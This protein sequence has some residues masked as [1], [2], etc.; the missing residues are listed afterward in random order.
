MVNYKI[1]FSDVDG[2]L[3]NTRHQVLP[4]TLLAIKSLQKQ[5][6]PFVI[7]SARSPSGIYPIQEKYGFNCPVISYSGALIMDE[8]K[9]VLYSKGFSRDLAG[10]VIEFIE[11]SRFDCSWNIYSKDT[12]V[13]KDRK[14]PRVAREENIVQAKAVEG[15]VEILSEDAD[16]GKI[17]CIC[18]PDCILDIERKLKKEFPSLSVVK[19]SE[20]LLEVMHGSVT[21]GSAVKTLCGMWGI[22]LS[23]T[24]A[25]GDNYNDVEMLETV[26]MPFLMG[27]APEELKIKFP[28]V[29]ESNDEEGIY[30]GLT[31]IGLIPKA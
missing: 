23:N 9:R 26:A 18:D 22:P 4:G 11:A 2:T 28:N 21:K 14:D 19:S 12:W 17:L 13:V 27:N 15:T 1:V 31:K 10:K 25:F 30:A 3:L 24:V 29:T 8:S 6:I 16:V 5:D 7:V 20:I